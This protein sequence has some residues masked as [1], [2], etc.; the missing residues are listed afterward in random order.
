MER[1]FRG[2]VNVTTIHNRVIFA[3]TC[4][5]RAFTIPHINAATGVLCQFCLRFQ[6]KQS[7]PGCQFYELVG[8]LVVDAPITYGGLCFIH[9]TIHAMDCVSDRL[10]KTDIGAAS[11]TAQQIRLG[12]ID[13]DFTPQ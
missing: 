7:P 4:A 8:L 12:D 3:M 6:T 10:N 1:G 2:E 13:F 5:G 9:H 11:L